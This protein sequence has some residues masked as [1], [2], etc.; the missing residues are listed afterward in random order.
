MQYLNEGS[1]NNENFG[2]F[3]S[4]PS[5]PKEMR[6]TYSSKDMNLLAY[7]SDIKRNLSMQSFQENEPE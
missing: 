5:F 4:N 7:Q 6:R 2:K 1:E 3:I